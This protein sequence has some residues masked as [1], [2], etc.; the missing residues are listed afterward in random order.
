MPRCRSRPAISPVPVSAMRRGLPWRRSTACRPACSKG[1]RGASSSCRDSLASVRGN[2]LLPWWSS[3]YVHFPYTFIFIVTCTFVESESA[4]F[5]RLFLSSVSDAKLSLL[6]GGPMG[7][8]WGKCMKRKC[9]IP[10]CMNGIA[11]SY[12]GKIPG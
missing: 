8:E 2:G 5:F 7:D 4:V 11:H 9:A 6:Q 10:L 1:L 12:N 3:N